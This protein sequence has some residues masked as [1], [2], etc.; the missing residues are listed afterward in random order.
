MK[1][2]QWK[3]LIFP[4]TL[5]LAILTTLLDLHASVIKAARPPDVF[6]TAVAKDIHASADSSFC[7]VGP[8]LFHSDPV[9]EKGENPAFENWTQDFGSFI[10]GGC[11]VAI[12]LRKAAA[13]LLNGKSFPSS[14]QMISDCG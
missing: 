11:G 4:C 6:D 12:H 5:L 3:S 13:V 14:L 7:S 9:Q 1:H 10:F 8:F 2:H